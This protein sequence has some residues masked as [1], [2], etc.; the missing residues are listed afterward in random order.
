MKILSYSII[1]SLIL[2]SCNTAKTELSA[3]EVEALQQ[4]YADVFKP[5]DGVWRG[6]FYVYS[7]PNG[8]T[9]AE[10]AQP[11]NIDLSTLV[12]LNLKNQFVIDVEQRYTSDNPWYQRVEIKDTYLKDG[13]E[14]VVK[15]SGVNKVEE[16][17]L[18]CIVNKPDDQ[19]IHSGAWDGKNTITWE[20]DIREP[21][22]I[23]FFSETVTDSAYTI[24][25]WGYYGTDNPEL[26]PKT[27]F[28][29]DYK[30]VFED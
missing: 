10:S 29:G 26:N 11:K 14:Q 24:V 23:E 13:Q 6:Q 2:S 19:I 4:Q 18:L 21:L 27:W 7:D 17:K 16:G 8:Q 22:K 30:R 28:F 9:S 5:L 1:I 3:E 12:S 20:R 25:G 15:S